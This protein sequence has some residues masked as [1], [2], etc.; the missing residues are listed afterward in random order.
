MMLRLYRSFVF[1]LSCAFVVAA[2]PVTAQVPSDSEVVT[3][4]DAL[5]AKALTQPG[6]VGFSVAIARGDQIIL[7]KGYGLAEA[8]HDVVANAD[9][10]FRIG[11]I[12]K[13]YT[14]AAIMK[15][16]EQGKMTLDDDMTKYLPKYPTQGN[17]V[18]IRNL[19]NHTSGIQSYTEDDTFMERRT[20]NE[21]THD[22][23]LAEF[24]DDPFD[25]KPGEKQSYNNSAYYL[26][27]MIIEN[28]SGKTYADYLQDEFFTPLGLKH[29][30]YDSSSEVIKNRAQGYAFRQGQLINDKPIAMS[31]PGAAGALLCSAGDLVKWQIA[32][33]GGE[34]VSVESFELMTTPTTLPNGETIDYGFGLAME[35]YRDHPWIGHGGGIFGFNSMMKYFPEHR[36]HIAVIS[37]SQAARS[38]ALLDQI[39]NI[40]LGIP[41]EQVGDL[42]LTE[43]QMQRFVGS[44]QFDQI[45]L[46]TSIFIKEGKLMAQATNQDAFRL[47][48]QGEG[49]FRAD[50][51]HDVKL[52]F[53]T[54]GDKAA[55]FVLH[56]G[57]GRIQAKRIAAEQ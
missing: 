55:S 16:I 2:V 42:P 49:E 43:E 20:A 34:V 14:A 10:L 27:G 15:L 4:V 36:L 53:T 38:G 12:T 5:V 28:V 47:L 54:D 24:Q 44:Y 40:A 13:Q 22:E 11:S 52:I 51:D 7:S 23:M 33:V 8:E 18:T 19:L 30:R 17:T 31:I 48:Y 56:Q 39:A 50:F 21:L 1:A 6:A 25:F 26:L 29:S 3:Q 37:N 41:P 32:L 35:E 45:P 9:T 46:D 57:G